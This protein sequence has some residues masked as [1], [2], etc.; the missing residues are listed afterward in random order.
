MFFLKLFLG[1]L[2]VLL[3]LDLGIL[4]YFNIFLYASIY[5]KALKV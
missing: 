4:S 5:I 3:L 1:I 2:Y